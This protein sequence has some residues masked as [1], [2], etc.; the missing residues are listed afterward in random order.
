[1]MLCIIDAK[2]KRHVATCDIDGAVLRMVMNKRTHVILD[3][4][5]VDLI[6][7][8]NP[9]RYKD[10]VIYNKNGTKYYG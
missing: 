1:M 8:A 10:Y 4:K 6:V 2:E 3:R 9:S 5:M 7:T